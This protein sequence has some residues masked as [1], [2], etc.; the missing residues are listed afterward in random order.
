VAVAALTA[1]VLWYLHASKPRVDVAA[2]DQQVRQLKVA[3]RYADA[4]ALVSR[5]IATATETSAPKADLGAL[6]SL[7][8]DVLLFLGKYDE[9]DRELTDATKLLEHEGGMRL[10]I[11]LH[12]LGAVRF[13]QGRLA[14]S[15]ALYLRALALK[16][17]AS[18][19]DDASVAETLDNLGVTL[20]HLGR[21][22][23]AE[24]LHKRAVEIFKRFPELAADEATSLSNLAVTQISQRKHSEAEATLLQA[25]ALQKRVHGKDHPMIAGTL[26]SLAVCAF[27]TGRRDEALALQRESVAMYE[28][29]VSPD[30]PDLA[31]AREALADLLSE[32]GLAKEAASA[33][34][35]A[36]REEA[37]APGPDAGL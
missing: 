24:P 1:A 3:G 36:A 29:T 7:R 17:A 11:A 26:G 4:E 23:E 13:Y 37:P 8:G 6:R 20:N 35:P 5:G 12:N 31:R 21:P 15:E 27:E 22:A 14:E 25:L 32:P 34:L 33:K 9:A 18:P 30:H 28:R 2:I 19:A 10:G 16:Q